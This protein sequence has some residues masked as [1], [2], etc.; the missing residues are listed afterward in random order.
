[1]DTPERLD[2]DELLRLA[3][4]AT[5]RDQNG[6]AIEYLKRLLALEPDRA[7]A[8]YLLG[9]QQAQI[10]LPERAIASM[11][12]ALELRPQMDAAR[13]QLGMLQLT[14][15][16]VAEAEAVWEPLRGLGDEHPFVLFKTGLLHLVRDE[17]DACL[18]HLA[19]GIARNDINEALSVDMANIAEEVRRRSGVPVPAA[20]APAPAEDVP[21]MFLDA[22]KGKA[23]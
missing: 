15:G 3:L 13:F 5:E 17:F 11:Q 22:Y 16:R 1:M 8:L 10:G 2:A 18:D 14:S 7:D 23:H 12:R 6:S 19:R 20:S 21:A 4:T 9:A